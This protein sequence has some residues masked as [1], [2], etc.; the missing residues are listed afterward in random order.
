MSR[1]EKGDAKDKSTP[2]ES[3][4]L[5]MSHWAGLTF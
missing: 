4:G 1:R 2:N 3:A 5:E